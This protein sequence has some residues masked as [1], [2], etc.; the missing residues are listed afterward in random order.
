MPI[1]YL[2][3]VCCRWRG[4][5]TFDRIGASL[6]RCHLSWELTEKKPARRWLWERIFLAEEQIQRVEG[7]LESSRNKKKASV[8]GMQWAVGEEALFRGAWRDRQGQSFQ[9]YVGE[10]FELY[11]RCHLKVLSRNVTS[12]NLHF[13]LKITVA[14][15][16]TIYCGRRIRWESRRVLL[17]PL[18]QYW[19]KITVA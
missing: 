2:E 13:K 12:F 19:W 11:F 7:S 18:M 15:F 1:K 16:K 5:V 4:G 10:G 8:N 17:S 6:S 14:T 3:K 9:D